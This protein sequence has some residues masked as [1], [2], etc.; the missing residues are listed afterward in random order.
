MQEKRNKRLAVILVALCCVTV[1]TYLLGRAD[2]T[3]DVDKNLFKDFELKDIDQVTLESEKDTVVLKFNG[4]K[5]VVNEQFNADAS[6]IQVLFATLQQAEPKRPVSPSIR[7]SVSQSLTQDGVKVSLF[8]SGVKE[9]SFYAGGNVK[10]TQAVFSSE[11]TDDTPYIMTI[12]GYR[13]YVS[14][15]FELPEKDW[16]DKLVFGFNWRNFESLEATFPGSSDQG[17]KVSLLDNYFGIEGMASVDT[18]KLNQFL[19]DVSLL[20]AAEF[21]NN[22]IFGDSLSK[23]LPSM[24]I[25]VRDIA[26]R[27]YTLELY[28]RSNAMQ[29]VPGLINGK[30]WAFFPPQRIEDIFKKKAFFAE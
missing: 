6:M 30:Q 26:Q 18:A 4:S 3:V 8:A 25:T 2:G 9:T 11:E 5:W 29:T 20:T 23:P 22:P 21:V 15:I 16:K 14:G 24:L 17:F 27:A 7:D 1:A 19:D 28:H 13:V 12:P 10:K